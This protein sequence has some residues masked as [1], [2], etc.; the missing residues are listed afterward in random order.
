M[1]NRN[2]RLPDG[3]NGHTVAPMNVEGMPFYDKHRADNGRQ[4]ESAAISGKE[5][6]W[7]IWGALKAALVVTGIF[8]LAIVALVAVL[9]LAW[10]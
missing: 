7:M 8:A 9:Q 3:D 6:R 5:T 4:G 10:R 2:K 1:A